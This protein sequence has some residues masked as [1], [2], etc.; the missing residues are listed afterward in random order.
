[1]QAARVNEVLWQGRGVPL[2]HIF[3]SEVLELW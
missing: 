2:D 1:M 3:V